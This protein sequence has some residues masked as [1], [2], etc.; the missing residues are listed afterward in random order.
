MRYKTLITQFP[1]LLSGFSLIPVIVG[2][3]IEFSLEGRDPTTVT[4]SQLEIATSSFAFFVWALSQFLRRNALKDVAVKAGLVPLRPGS[5]V[6]MP[7]GF[8][9]LFLTLVM[10]GV[11]L[12]ALIGQVRIQ[13]PGLSQTTALLLL[14]YLPVFWFNQWPGADL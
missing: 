4:L 3:A 2:R 12:F 11:M 9:L 13:I 5:A 8:V 10:M 6:E 14:C 7:V 1:A